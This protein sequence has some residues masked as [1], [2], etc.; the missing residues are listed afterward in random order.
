MKTLQ[1]QLE[2][3][4]WHL[5]YYG[6]I[7]NVGIFRWKKDISKFYTV[8]V[9]VNIANVYFNNVILLLGC[10]NF[11]FDPKRFSFGR[12]AK[13]CTFVVPVLL[14]LLTVVCP[15]IIEFCAPCVAI[16]VGLSF[17]PLAAL[18]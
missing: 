18:I 10:C 5:L 3:Y 12:P 8:K 7:C 9:N 4:F 14:F 1:Y 6:F 11:P 15:K 17:C 16:Y 2:S 13:E